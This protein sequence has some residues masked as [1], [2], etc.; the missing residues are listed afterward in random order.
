MIP[1]RML[2]TGQR[3]RRWRRLVGLA[4]LALALLVCWQIFGPPAVVRDGPHSSHLAAAGPRP[5]LSAGASSGT[6]RP[7]GD[8]P[9]A[10]VLPAAA[11]EDEHPTPRFPAALTALHAEGGK[12]LSDIIWILLQGRLEGKSLYQIFTEEPRDPE[13]APAME[14]AVL[15][16][17]RAHLAQRP[18]TEDVQISSV[19]CHSSACAIRATSSTAGNDK[20]VLTRRFEGAVRAHIASA[21]SSPVFETDESQ[22]PPR[23]VMVTTIAFS[24][25]DIEPAAYA[26]WFWKRRQR[27]ETDGS[28]RHPAAP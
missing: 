16:T 6:R 10:I 8:R 17:L 13:W 5:S 14:A 2:V 11:R 9:S 15:T 19:E 28:A 24:E 7:L 20:E 1:S 18:G 25:D 12:R 23:L 4:L 3:R 27:D 21:I 26:D 22:T